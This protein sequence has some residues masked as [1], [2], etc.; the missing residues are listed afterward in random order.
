MTSIEKALRM[1]AETHEGQYRKDSTKDRKVPYITHPVMCAF[2]LRQHGFA[3]EVVAAALVHD[4]LEDTSISEEAMRLALG[5]KV[6]DLVLMVTYDPALS[7]EE[8]RVA[9]IQKLR[10]APAEAKAI[11]V[12]DKIH[13]AQSLLDAHAIQGPAI[14]AHFT[15]P[16]EKKL[17][18][19]GEMLAMLQETWKHPLVDEYAALYEQMKQLD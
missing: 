16:K 17:W 12:A 7:W 5:N 11:S 8:Q 13:N 18:F 4:V 19:E 15:R 14:W 3:D 6:T 9:Y 1:A 10:A 2:I